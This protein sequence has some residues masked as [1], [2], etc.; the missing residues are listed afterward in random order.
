[1]AAPPLKNQAL[2]SSKAPNL[3]IAPVAYDQRYQDQLNNAFRL[4]F[5]EIDNFTQA[6]AIPVSGTTA[7]RPVD[8]GDIKLK[9]G[10]QYFDTTINRPIWWD[11]TNWINAAGT[12][13]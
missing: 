7:S 12:V 8:T 1:M 3:P 5:A 6:A 9:I 13:V 10:Q 11:G 4:Y 2:R